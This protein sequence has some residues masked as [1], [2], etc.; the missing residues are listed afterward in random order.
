SG[1]SL[2]TLIISSALFIPI[3]ISLKCYVITPP[4]PL[5]N[6]P[7]QG[8]E[9]ECPQNTNVCLKTYDRNLNTIQKTCGTY[10]AN[11]TNQIGTPNQPAQCFNSTT[12]TS[13]CCYGDRC[14]SS[15]ITSIFVG[16]LLALLAIFQY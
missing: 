4:Q 3:V 11:C 1:M 15:S 10:G 14:N 12:T 5:T 16:L 9:T 13:C 8:T 2:R 7:A 6:P